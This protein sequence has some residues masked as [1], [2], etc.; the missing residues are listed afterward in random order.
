MN[1]LW[2]AARYIKTQSLGVDGD[3]QIKFNYSDIQT[4]L[5]TYVH[6]FGTFDLWILHVFNDFMDEWRDGLSLQDLPRYVKKCIAF[7]EEEFCD[8]YLEISKLNN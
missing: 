8:W 6:D 5:E 1:K 3:A 2:N 7:V 4:S